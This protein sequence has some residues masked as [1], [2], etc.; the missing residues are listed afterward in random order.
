MPIIGIGVDTCHLPHLHSLLT[1]HSPWRLVRRIFT[2]RERELFEQNFGALDLHKPLSKYPNPEG[3]PHWNRIPPPQRRLL[4]YLGGRWAAKEAAFKALYPTYHLQFRDVSILKEQ[5][6]KP[7]IV[8]SPDIVEAANVSASHVS[9]SHDGEIAMAY[10]VFERSCDEQTCA[11]LT[12][13]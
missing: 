4:S 10:V 9:L 5:G 2:V 13:Q 6:A 8:L 3:G 12:K 1:R 11:K 7:C